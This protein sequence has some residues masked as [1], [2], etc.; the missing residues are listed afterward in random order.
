MCNEDGTIWIVHNG[1]V[2]N[3]VELRRELS[4]RGHRFA[5]NS[6]TEVILHAYEQWGHECLNRFNG[7]WA[8][9][10]W[11]S[12][13]RKLFCARDRFGV[14]PFYY[15]FKESVFA[16]ASEIKP[17]LSLGMPRTP[18]N[19]LAYDFL[20]W[21]ILEHTQETFFEGIQKLAPSHYMSLDLSG[22]LRVQRYWELNVSGEI[23]GGPDDRACSKTFL[24]SFTTA[25]R[26]RLRS[27]VPVG[28]CLS[29]GLDSSSIVCV[30]SRLRA[31]DRDSSSA[32]SQMTFSSCFDD[33]RF[34]ERKYIEEVVRK[35]R[36]EKRYVF[37]TSEGFLRELD[38]LLWR[39]EEPFAGTSVYAQWLLM[40][41]ARSCGVT[42]MLDGQGGDEQLCGYRKFY[43]FYLMHLRKKGQYTR[44]FLEAWRFFSSME[45]LRTLKLRQG[46]RYFGL[47]SKI[48][49]VED[50]L[51]ED[52]RRDFPQRRLD[53]GYYP[54][55]GRRIWA[56]LFA[57]S[58]PVLLR[59]A[60]KNAM[61]H[62]V[63]ARFP[64][65]DYRLAETLASFPLTQ[66]IRNKWTKH[67]LREAMSGVLPEKVRLRKSKLGLDT[68]QD[69]WFKK[70]ALGEAVAST[71][72]QPRFIGH[73][74]ATD[75]LVSHFRRYLAGRSLYGSEIFFRLFI[76]ELWGRKFILE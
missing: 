69:A 11:D 44:L 51:S 54:N 22:N 37:P 28:S 31:K 7:M 45:V 9:C 2:Y 20:R 41:E 43:I 1:E 25:V 32:N 27:D 17:L 48:L 5:S 60:D 46:L 10:L 47:G 18:N 62:S 30:T 24:E 67:V 63:E 6:D 55:L 58:L 29:G 57:F 76:L 13:R 26:L 74:A 12:R 14:K 16:F 70:S 35:A 39:Q 65:L 19:A 38:Q 73:Y 40:K 61:A 36:T 71:F 23:E 49:P 72:E 53:F 3:F 21:G 75:S 33:P 34:D 8:F 4:A 64:F 15:Y 59:Y 68:P 42:V 50:L 52:L 56:D 66:K